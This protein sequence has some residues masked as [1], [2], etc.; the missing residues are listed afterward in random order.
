MEQYSKKREI[1]GYKPVRAVVFLFFALFLLSNCQVKKSLNAAL[2]NKSGTEHS[3]A[4]INKGL[5]GS[6]R[7]MANEH[8]LLGKSSAYSDSDLH[9]AA[10]AAP[11]Q[12][13]ESILLSYLPILLIFTRFSGDA[14]SPL[15]S[16]FKVL[17]ASSG[18]PIY[19][20]NR[21]LLI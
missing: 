3:T 7:I 11:V 6:T 19:I 4:R 17:P 14:H 12:P 10:D 21:Y 15:L 9:L 16:L 18:S 2:L 1:R 5:P 13:A 20:K 8:C